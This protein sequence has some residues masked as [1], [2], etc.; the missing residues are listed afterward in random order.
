MAWYPWNSGRIALALTG[1]AGVVVLAPAL[2]SPA[3]AEA[4]KALAVTAS[5]FKDGGMIPDD[6][7]FCVAAKEGH[8]RD[9]ANKNPA[10]KWSKGPS[11]TQS[12]AIIMVDTDVPSVFDDADKEG[13][14]IPAG[15]K[16]INFYH[17][18]LVDIPATRTELAEGADSNGITAKGK[19]PGASP[20]GVR[21]INDYSAAF[22]GDPKMEG[23]YGG[24]DGPCPPWNDQRLHHY[25]FIVYA[26]DVPSLGL[27][28]RF[29]PKDAEA[30]I[31]KHTLAKGEVI[32][33]YTQNP[34]LIRKIKRS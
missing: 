10:I 29:G 30:A 1:V 22:A 6:Y 14:T 13:K 5:G 20:N 15:M 7:A 8:S 32:G 34:D 27:S 21:G 31:A 12:Y 18:V 11:G 28:G 4:P 23:S 19:P 25:H 9:G 16:R 26:M 24:Y 33:V 17:M 3:E 2:R